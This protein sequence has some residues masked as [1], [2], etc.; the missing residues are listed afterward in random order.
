MILGQ[1][2]DNDYNVVYNKKSCKAIN[3]KDDIVLFSGIKKNNIYKEELREM[4]IT[5]MIRACKLEIS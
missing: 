1:L 2:S 4:A 3:K 5:H